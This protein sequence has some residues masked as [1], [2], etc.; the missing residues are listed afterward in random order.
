MHFLLRLYW[1]KRTLCFVALPFC[2]TLFISS[3]HFCLVPLFPLC[4]KIDL[5]RPTPC[6]W[7]LCIS[8][9]CDI[10][11]GWLHKNSCRK[12]MQCHKSSKCWFTNCTE[13]KKINLFLQTVFPPRFWLVSS[14]PCTRKIGNFPIA[15]NSYSKMSW[16]V[17]NKNADSLIK[18]SLVVT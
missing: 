11:K 10:R 7:Q 5:I 8:K 6:H 13:S 18:I 17:S 9:F 16:R 2:I 3:A 15:N 14:M 12:A 1:L 4:T